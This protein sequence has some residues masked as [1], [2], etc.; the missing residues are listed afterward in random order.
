M[1]EQPHTD[2]RE[3]EEKAE[4]LRQQA[5]RLGTMVEALNKT[6]GRTFPPN[7]GTELCLLEPRRQRFGWGTRR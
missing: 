2:A 3:L 4:E 7:G 5:D 6:M 1:D